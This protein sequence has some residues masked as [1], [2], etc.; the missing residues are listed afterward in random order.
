MI[1][2]IKVGQRNTTLHA[3]IERFREQG[4]EPD[5]LAKKI[6]DWNEKLCERP[7]SREEVARLLEVG[8]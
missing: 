5:A 2:Q 8:S 6:H 4:M 1:L 3:F 7:L